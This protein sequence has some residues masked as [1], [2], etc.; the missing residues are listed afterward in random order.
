MKSDETSLP[1]LGYK[2]L[3]SALLPLSCLLTSLLWW[4]KL[5]SS[6]MLCGVAHVARN[7]KRLPAVS[8]WGTEVFVQSAKNTELARATWVSPAEPQEAL[9][10]LK[11]SYMTQ[12]FY[13]SVC[14]KSSLNIIHRF[15]EFKQNQV[16]WNQFY[17]RLTDINK[18]MAS[19]QH[20]NK[21]TLFKDLL[22]TIIEVKTI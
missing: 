2:R 10:K 21:M 12:Q 22:N 19:H 13:S 18:S 1:C 15:C 9:W 8:S 7:Q 5:P 11:Q 3:T 16:W 6:K 17:H 4:I 20:Y 14:S